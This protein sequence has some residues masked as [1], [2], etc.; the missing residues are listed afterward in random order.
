M[1]IGCLGKNELKGLKVKFS[2]FQKLI[3]INDIK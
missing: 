1:I 3:F 2:L